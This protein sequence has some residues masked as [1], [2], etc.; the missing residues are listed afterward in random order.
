MNKDVNDR[1]KR[2][3]SQRMYLLSI[4][5]QNIDNWSFNIE[6]STGSNYSVNFTEKHV[7]CAC[8]DFKKRHKICKHI[9]FIVARVLKDSNL[10]SLLNEDP[11]INIFKLSEN[12]NKNLENIMK[13]CQNIEKIS[14]VKSEQILSCSDDCV[15]C[16]EEVGL[17][18]FA[19]SCL[20]C[21]KYLHT[22]C[23][24]RWLLQKN[25]CPLCRS[26]WSIID[27]VSDGSDDALYK[28]KI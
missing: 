12:L 7:K 10:V 8:I 11:N 26:I 4:N 20:T 9:I 3:L 2:A 17:V 18:T 23:L 21:K 15:I 27:F 28:L 13:P 19:K 5:Q 1:I 16:Y 14:E 24:N 25:S 6:G 22:D